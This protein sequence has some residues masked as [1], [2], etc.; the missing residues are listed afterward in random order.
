[1]NQPHSGVVLSAWVAG[2]S[3]RYEEVRRDR[4]ALSPSEAQ[5]FGLHR[6]GSHVEDHRDIPAFPSLSDLH[7]NTSPPHHF[8]AAPT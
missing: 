1:M 7:G 8:A 2:V 4:K 6:N 5:L 3:P